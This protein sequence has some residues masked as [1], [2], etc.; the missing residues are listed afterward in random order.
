[1]SVMI[2]TRSTPSSAWAALVASKK[3]APSAISNLDGEAL[4]L[5]ISVPA[6]LSIWDVQLQESRVADN[7]CEG[8]AL[9]NKTT[10]FRV[11][12]L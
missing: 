4:V 7:R 8:M 11:K 3:D 6:F 1:M 5:V 10:G 9:C 2:P 12:E